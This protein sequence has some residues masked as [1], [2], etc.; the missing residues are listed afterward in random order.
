VDDSDVLLGIGTDLV[1]VARFRRVTERHGEGF[2][3]RLFPPAE[4]E[5]WRATRR[6]VEHLAAGFA[7]REAVVKAL[8]TGLVGQM[9]WRDIE[10][11]PS[12]GRGVYELELRGAV[13]AQAERLGA[14]RVLLALTATREVAAATVVITGNAECTMHTAECMEL[15][16]ES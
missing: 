14:S 11:V 1:D 8:G 3:E 2:L 9:S 7:A 13:R 4:L 6:S 16:P 5:R 12:G 15:T 10:V